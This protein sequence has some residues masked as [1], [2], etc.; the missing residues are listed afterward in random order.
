MPVTVATDNLKFIAGLVRL[1]VG[2]NQLLDA[3][4]GKVQLKIAEEITGVTAQAVT[5]VVLPIFPNRRVIGVTENDLI[6][7]IFSIMPQLVLYRRELGL[8]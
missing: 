7:E 5:E 4:L 3:K 8:V 1:V 6:L 2:G